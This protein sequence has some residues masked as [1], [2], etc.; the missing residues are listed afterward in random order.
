MQGA[1]PWVVIN[2]RLP[3]ELIEYKT[4]DGSNWT[5][6]IENNKFIHTRQGTNTSHEANIINYKTWDGS[7]WTAQIDGTKL[8]H[9]RQGASASHEAVRI[10]YLGSD[11]VQYEGS[12][13][14]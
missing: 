3:D 12:F 9:T 6:R 1:R 5:A 8:I 7:N 11:G 14:N 10:D 13:A 4:W 2:K